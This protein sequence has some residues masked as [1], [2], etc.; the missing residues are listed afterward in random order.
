VPGAAYTPIIYD[1]AISTL[2]HSPNARAFLDYLHS[3]AA[4]DIMHADGLETVK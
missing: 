3:P 4:T 1:A 2:T